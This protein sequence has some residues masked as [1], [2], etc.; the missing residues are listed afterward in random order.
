ML[1]GRH[2]EPRVWTGLLER[3]G[4]KGVTG[5]DP[6]EAWPACG[7][8]EAGDKV[9]GPEANTQSPSWETSHPRSEPSSA[10]SSRSREACFLPPPR[11]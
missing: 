8:L 6:E 4:A 5:L 10:V 11:Y 9:L 7:F 1:L 3:V 2:G